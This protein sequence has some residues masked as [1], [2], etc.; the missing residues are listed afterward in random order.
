MRSFRKSPLRGGLYHL[1]LILVTTTAFNLGFLRLTSVDLAA[2]IFA[3]VVLPQAAIA[4]AICIS[5]VIVLWN[6]WVD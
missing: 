3:G 6:N 1:A 4:A 5:S 2:R